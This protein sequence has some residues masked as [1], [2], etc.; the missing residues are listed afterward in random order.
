VV[1]VTV[2]RKTH[3]LLL[4]KKETKPHKLE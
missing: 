2:F 1:F 4:R 3:N